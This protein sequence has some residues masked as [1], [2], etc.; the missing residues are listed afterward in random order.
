MTSKTESRLEYLLTYLVYFVY[1]RVDLDL[2]DSGPFRR[3]FFF[4]CKTLFTYRYISLVR[5]QENTDLYSCSNFTHRV[6]LLSMST[7]LITLKM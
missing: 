5:G 7:Y 6:N 2:R 3:N 4:H 1:L